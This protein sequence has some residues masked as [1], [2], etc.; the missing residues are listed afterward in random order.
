MHAD[1]VEALKAQLAERFCQL[2]A[3]KGLTGTELEKRTTHNRKN[4]SAIRNRGRLPTRDILQ[5]YDQVFGTR[6]ELTDLGERI[7]A[8]QKAVRLTELT[9]AAGVD[10]PEPQAAESEGEVRGTDRR[11]FFELTAAL[12]ADTYRRRA[13]LGPD[14]LTL[15]SLDGAVD[16]HAA[17][18]T[19]TPHDA[20]APE[21]FRTWQSAEK[22]IESGVKPRAHAKLT[23]VAGLSAYMLARLA[24]N[25][26]DQ[27]ASQQLVIQARDHAEQIDDDVLTASVAAMDST[28]CFYRQQYDEAAKIV[29]K[30]GAVAD[31][32]YTRARLFAYEARAYAAFGDPTATREALARMNAAVIETQPRPGSSPFGRANADWFTAGLLARL[33]AGTEAEPLA[34]QAV[35]AFDSG[36]AT[37]FEDHGH[38]LMVLATTLLRRERPDPAEAAMLGSRALELVADRPTHT[39]VTRACRLVNDLSGYG[40]VPEVTS[41]REQLTTAPRP[42]LMG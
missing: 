6:S 11:T 14:A 16:R 42:A 30:A 39:V 38:A 18:F 23:R 21:V 31:H 8:A 22:H 34:R 25:M 28:L 12:A 24:F 13:R 27:D 41:F 17:A 19:S 3:E 10:I 33:G 26:G 35:E 40:S 5:A 4:A 32:P 37:G 36:R 9:A 29:R 2:Q 15:A 1:G 7:R 20:L